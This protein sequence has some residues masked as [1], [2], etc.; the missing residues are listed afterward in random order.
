MRS[1]S[2]SF[3]GP[4]WLM[5][6]MPLVGVGMLVTV[7]EARPR[8]DRPFV[9]KPDGIV[10]RPNICIKSPELDEAWTKYDQKVDAEVLRLA[11]ECFGNERDD[12]LED[13][14]LPVTCREAVQRYWTE[15][16]GAR[17]VL[18][19]AYDNH[20]HAQAARDEWNR[21]I[22]TQIPRRFP[23]D[24]EYLLVEDQVARH[25]RIIRVESGGV[26]WLV[27]TWTGDEQA[28]CT[29]KRG[30]S[31]PLPPKNDQPS[32]TLKD[33]KN[34]ENQQKGTFTVDRVIQT[35]TL[36]L[37]EANGRHVGNVEGRIEPL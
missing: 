7:A 35:Y 28:V 17:Q 16:A 12:L 5:V 22:A 36:K 1:W 37:Y 14:R 3:P 18:Q 6:M 4:L 29:E 27:R 20:G 30:E 2:A 10:L 11:R 8:R 9:I 32:M 34:P 25:G 31:I 23:E 19:R 24:G 26:L 21:D 15:V 13:G 33:L